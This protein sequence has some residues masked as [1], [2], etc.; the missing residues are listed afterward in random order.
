MQSLTFYIQ[1]LIL[2]YSKFDLKIK[3][4]HETWKLVFCIWI[5]QLW[6]PINIPIF[7]NTFNSVKMLLAKYGDV[8]GTLNPLRPICLI[9]ASSPRG[10]G[11]VSSQLDVLYLRTSPFSR[12]SPCC[13][14]ARLCHTLRGSPR[15]LFPCFTQ[16][17]A[18]GLHLP[19]NKSCIFFLGL[20]F[21]TRWAAAFDFAQ[22]ARSCLPA[23]CLAR[24]IWVL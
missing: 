17:I 6:H 15:F 13:S 14:S 5:N 10:N 21:C 11:L 9:C 18:F 16:I 1:I 19:N 12:V 8:S 3:N 20:L 7:L 4:I 24:H 23:D 2:K 22:T